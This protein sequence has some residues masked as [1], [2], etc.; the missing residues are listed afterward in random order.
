MQKTL[1]KDSEWNIIDGAICRV[2]DFVPLESSVKDGKVI[3]TDKT[4]PYASITIEYKYSAQKITGLITHKLD[5]KHLWEAFKERGIKKDEEE[6]LI[7]WTI[8]HYKFKIYKWLSASMPKLWVMICPKKAYEL[9]N[10]P[11]YKRDLEGEARWLAQK[12]IVE[13]KPEVMK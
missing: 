5:F 12:P 6:V 9:W 7:V 11:A 2:I 10:Y 1:R 8:K 4:T 13:W 3:T